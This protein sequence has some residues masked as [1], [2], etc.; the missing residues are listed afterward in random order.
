[1]Q[2]AEASYHGDKC[3]PHAWVILGQTCDEHVASLA[4]LETLTA[5]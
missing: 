3:N 4:C 2:G 1:M 5:Y